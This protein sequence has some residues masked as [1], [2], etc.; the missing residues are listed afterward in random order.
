[1]D[2][3]ILAINKALREVI[4]PLRELQK[5]AEIDAKLVLSEAMDKL[6][7]AQALLSDIQG[8]YQDLLDEKE[9]LSQKIMQYEKWTEDESNYQSFRLNT[10]A[11]VMIT[12]EP[13]KSPYSKEWYCKHCF[14]N[15]KKSLLQS[16]PR[17]SFAFRC[18]ECKIEIGLDPGDFNAITT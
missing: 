18:P 12:K 14:D 15:K 2:K 10:G 13:N 7:E 1:M 17:N 6:I 11:T 16:V 8:S 4:K 5:D 3:T 9:K